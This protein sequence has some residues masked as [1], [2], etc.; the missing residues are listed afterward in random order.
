M[1]VGDTVAGGIPGATLRIKGE[2]DA[3]GFGD[4]EAGALAD[5]DDGEFGTEA[6][7][8][9]VADGDTGLCRDDDGGD[10]EIIEAG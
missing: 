2:V 7:A 6:L 10:F 8:D 3:E 1:D 5:E 4:G 9:V